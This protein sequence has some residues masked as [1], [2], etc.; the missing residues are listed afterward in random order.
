VG[1]QGL[2]GALVDAGAVANLAVALA[3]F[4][5]ASSALRAMVATTGLNASTSSER[6]DLAASIGPMETNYGGDQAELKR[7]IHK[8]QT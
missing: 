2:D 5:P 7:Q 8:W 3:A 1:N 4:C 6:S